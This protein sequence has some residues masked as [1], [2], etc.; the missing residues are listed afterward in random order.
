MG[1]IRG[2]DRP[3]IDRPRPLIRS[4]DRSGPQI[5]ASVSN[6]G[7]SRPIPPYYAAMHNAGDGYIKS[8]TN[9]NPMHTPHAVSASA[10]FPK[11]RVQPLAILAVVQPSICAFS[12]G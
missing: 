10:L 9:S 6:G 5:W 8:S 4:S 1:R 12:C 11:A 3:Q 2:A 7:P